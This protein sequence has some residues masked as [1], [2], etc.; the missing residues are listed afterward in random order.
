MSSTLPLIARRPTGVGFVQLNN[1]LWRVTRASGAVLGYVEQVPGGA[2]V[3]GHPQRYAAKR[4]HASG[5][6]FLPVGEFW[7]FDDAVDCLR[8]G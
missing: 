5:R 1:G 4:L 6:G 8:F 7:S 3:E 2:A